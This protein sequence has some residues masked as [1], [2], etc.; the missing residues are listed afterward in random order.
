M[1][2]FRQSNGAGGWPPLTVNLAQPTLPENTL[3]FVSFFATTEP[4]FAVSGTT[5]VPEHIVGASA[6]TQIHLYRGSVTGNQVRMDQPA[7]NA[8][9]IY[10]EV[11]EFNGD[12]EP[13]L[14]NTAQA[15]TAAMNSGTVTPRN[16]GDLLVAG[17]GHAIAG[18]TMTPGGAPW[19][20][21]PQRS[22]SGG[23]NVRAAYREDSPTTAQSFTATNSTTGQWRGAIASFNRVGGPEPPP[24][25]QANRLRGF[26]GQRWVDLVR[27]PGAP[28]MSVFDGEDWLEL[29]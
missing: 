20:A 16:A 19:V 15:T 12:W 17:L 1:S 3:V 23:W 28:A 13:D 9:S 25:G 14:S 29:T 6:Q 22:L 27:A 7:G 24:A 21:L 18:A 11:L 10:Y 5:I 2:V 4:R 26:N 8:N